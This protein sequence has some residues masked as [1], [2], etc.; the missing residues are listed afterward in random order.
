MRSNNCTSLIGSKPVPSS[1]ILPFFFSGRIIRKCL[2]ES[3]VMWISCTDGE[4]ITIVD[5]FY[6]RSG[7]PPS[8]CPPMQKTGRGTCEDRHARLR[9]QDFCE[10]RSMCDIPVSS[11]TFGSPCPSQHPTYLTVEYECVSK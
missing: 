8:Y 6:G 3:D 9:V 7:Y 11:N 5:A 10:G 2:L 1:C 4:T